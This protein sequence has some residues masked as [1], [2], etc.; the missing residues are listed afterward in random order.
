MGYA[1]RKDGKGWRVVE[2]KSDINSDEVY[3]TTKPDSQEPNEYLL[4]IIELEK[5]VTDRRLREAIIGVDNG[6]L[7]DVDSKIAELR[8]KL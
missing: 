3:K 5:S 6:W 7:A 4:K 1:V 2:S 8:S